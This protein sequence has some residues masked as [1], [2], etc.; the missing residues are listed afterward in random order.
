MALVMSLV[1]ETAGDTLKKVIAELHAAIAGRDAEIE[2]L[3]ADIAAIV[4]AGA[5]GFRQGYHAAAS[6][7]SGIV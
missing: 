5:R 6:Q 3:K 2:R 7:F 1:H 4:Q